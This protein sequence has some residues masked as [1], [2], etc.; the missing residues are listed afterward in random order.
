[1]VKN[2]K[3][4]NIIV[5][6]SGGPDS[7]FLLSKLVKKKYKIIVAHVNYHFRKES[8]QEEE[9]VKKIC[10]ENSF[11]FERLSVD[12]KI[13]KIYSK[14]NNNQ[15]AYARLIRYDFFKEIAKKYQT[16][17][18]FLGH[19]KD[20]FL[21]TAIMQE[22]RSNKYL[23]YGINK[24]NYYQN[25]ILIRPFINKYW[26]EEIIE[27]LNKAKI[28]YKID[29]SNFSDKY[30][31]NQIRKKLF[32][33]NL[34]E[35]EKMLDYYKKINSANERKRKKIDKIFKNWR[36]KDYDVDFFNNQK[37][38]LKENLIYK[39]LS[40]QFIDENIS[41]NNNKIKAIILFIKNKR[42]NKNYRLKENLF[43][44]I[45]NQKL[46]FLKDNFKIN[47]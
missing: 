4:K 31:R 5:A 40:T 13:E 7:I 18:L 12:K 35:K 29:K 46:I 32:L 41:I 47:N 24:K 11:I 22:K 21:E 15:E 25:L 3:N 30:L 27:K 8:N 33:L 39:Y 19:H 9:L 44:K 28:D 42:G 23:F 10:N 14:I 16:N 43:L 20:D 6:V 34:K 45:K 36:I 1:M 26:K 17:Y 38:L 37:D 2:I